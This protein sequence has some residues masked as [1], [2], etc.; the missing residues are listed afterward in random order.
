MFRMN[1]T[2]FYLPQVTFA[3]EIM[4]AINM[5]LVEKLAVL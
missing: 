5:S 2:V 4:F 1:L 3:D